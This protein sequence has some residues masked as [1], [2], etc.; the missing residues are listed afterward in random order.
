[1]DWSKKEQVYNLEKYQIMKMESVTLSFI[2]Y[3]QSSDGKGI[4]WLVGR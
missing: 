1:M 2:W 3:A 4:D